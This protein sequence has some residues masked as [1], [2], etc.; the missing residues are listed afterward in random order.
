M[1]G[2]LAVLRCDPVTDWQ[3]MSQGR[4]FKVYREA[5]KC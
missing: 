3:V 4:K 1:K 2:G 5:V